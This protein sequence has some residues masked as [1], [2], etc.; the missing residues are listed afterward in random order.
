M[1][2]KFKFLVDAK[3]QEGASAEEPVPSIPRQRGRPKDG[4][5][6]H[7]DYEQV[8]AYIRKNT[9]H[10]VKLTLLQEGK[11]RQFSDLVEDLL[12]RWLKSNR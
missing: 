8:T 4:K 3:K 12:A 6:S 9:H 2:N 7:P 10:E 5:R 1:T 11:G